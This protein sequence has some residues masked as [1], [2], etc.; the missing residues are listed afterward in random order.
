M[1]EVFTYKPGDRLTIPQLV[2]QAKDFRLKLFAR[3]IGRS[4]DDAGEIIGYLQKSES[5]DLRRERSLLRDEIKVLPL[6]QRL[7]QTSPG[8]RLSEIPLDVKSL[9]ELSQDMGLRL[10]KE[11]LVTAM[12]RLLIKQEQHL[13]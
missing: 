3:T 1:P 6:V 10:S 9:F 2:N 11:R 13:Q 5:L 12:D 8:Q 4:A 7:E